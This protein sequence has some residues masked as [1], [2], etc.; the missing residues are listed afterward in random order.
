MT[1]LARLLAMLLLLIGLGLLGAEHASAAAKPSAPR[2]V[3]AVAGNGSA[4]VSWKAPAR[5]GG[6]VIRKYG[7][8][9]RSGSD[10]AWT[11]VATV[12]GT[13]LSWQATGLRN[14]TSYELRV[15]A[16]GKRWGRPSGAVRVTPRTVPDAPGAPEADSYA[17]ALGVYWKA[18]SG[19]GAAIDFYRVETS[20]NGSSWTPAVDAPAAGTSAQPVML[21]G[22][23]PGARYWVRVRAHNAAGFGDLA[24]TGPYTARTPPGAPTGL[25]ATPGSGSVALAWTPSPV[26]APGETAA[27]LYRV[28]QSVDGGASWTLA[29]ET[30]DP[31][32]DADGLTNGVAHL[33]RVSARSTTVRIG[34]GPASGTVAA[35]PTGAPTVPLDLALVWDGEQATY[36]LTW[37]PPASDG[38]YPVSH[39]LVEESP[40]SVTTQVDVPLT[41]STAGAAALDHGYRVTA[42]NQ[43]GCG[44]WAGP[45]GPAGAPPYVLSVSTGTVTLDE[46]TTTTFDVGLGFAALADT[47]VSLASSDPSVGVDATVTIPAGSS[48]ASVTVTA[49]PDD[50]ADDEAATITATL[51]GQQRTVAVTV[52]DTTLPPG[53]VTFASP[54]LTRTSPTSYTVGLA[55]TS[56]GTGPVTGYLVRRSVDGGEF[57][58]LGTTTTPSY[59]D[60]GAAPL[61]SYAYR[62]VP[63]GPAGDG[64]ATD[65][66]VTTGPAYTLSASPSTVTVTEGS[67]SSFVVSLDAPAL[68]DVA[69]TAGSSAPGAV[70]VSGTVTIPTGQTSAVVQ[71][72]GMQ[73]IGLAD[74]AATVTV[75][76]GTQQ[77]QVAV[78]V[79]DDDTQALVVDPTGPID[80]TSPGASAD[81]DVH[82]AFQPSGPVTVTLAYSGNKAHTSVPQLT[83]TPEDWDVD[84]AFTITKTGNNETAT[85]TMTTP[86]AAPVQIQVS[87]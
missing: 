57:S 44:A 28:E 18:P 56:P 67:N 42:C 55:W 39:Y 69:I 60:A 31:A 5:R 21:T 49:N 64:P 20:T 52:D 79:I 2:A 36:L 23:V 38:G 29:G 1:M 65:L 24:G 30:T 3:I 54:V 25:T 50:D 62:V 4:T 75:A 33:F 9:R 71:V 8:Q 13:K 14:G 26:D 40:G 47:A 68:T 19:N 37:S 46:G 85:L 53:Q 34:F 73:D 51:G 63:H 87:T 7:I 80:L 15:R 81:V 10:A 32:F 45:I 61:T 22:L 27:G 6:S 48:S 58:D 72:D 77:R 78:T 59:V 82:L 74:D 86:G 84:Q 70:T 17:G 16:L 41:S 35:T 43:A 12:R 76:L 11:T 66:Q 83:F